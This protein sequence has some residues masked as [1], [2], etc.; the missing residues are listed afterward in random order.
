VAVRAPVLLLLFLALPILLAAED[1]V[2]VDYVCSADDIDKFGLTCS[3]DEPCD[4][5]LELASAEGVGSSVFAAG[6]L[7]TVATTLYGVLLMS[8][9]GG[10]TWTE[11]NPRIQG[12]VLDQVQFA[13]SQ[14]GW[15]SGVTE[16]PL[17]RDP[18]LLVTAD[19]GKTWRRRPLFNETHYGSIQQFWFDSTKTG[20]LI[21]DRTHG[22]ASVYE[23]YETANGGDTWTIKEAGSKNPVLARA[24][25]KDSAAW[26]VRADAASKTNRIERRTARGA[27]EMVASFAVRAGVCK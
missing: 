19:G 11:P 22:S 14:H 15:A 17:A 24:P 4:V 10:K 2:R 16:E 7:H 20:E 6:N 3:E 26:R 18:F 13:D 23:I 25:A 5:F 9:D 1:P 27:W 12:A 8:G 21:L